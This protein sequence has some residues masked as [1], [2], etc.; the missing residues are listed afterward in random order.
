MY[1]HICKKETYTG[2]TGRETSNELMFSNQKKQFKDYSNV[3]I[4]TYS[5]TSMSYIVSIL[6][7][8]ESYF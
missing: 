5:M 7:G 1:A 3:K 4:L 6:C 2:K 8:I